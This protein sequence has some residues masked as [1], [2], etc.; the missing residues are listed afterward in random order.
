MNLDNFFFN[1]VSWKKIRNKGK[2]RFVERPILVLITILVIILYYFESRTKGNI[3]MS[4]TIGLIVGLNLYIVGISTW[5]WKEYM[6][7]R[8]I[9]NIRDF[10]AK[11]AL[12]YMANVFRI[13][14]IVILCLI[15]FYFVYFYR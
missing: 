6:F 9:N 8:Y 11:D 12:I 1:P 4:A 5:Y 15:I 10:K 13:A 2:N 7:K 3:M 14:Y